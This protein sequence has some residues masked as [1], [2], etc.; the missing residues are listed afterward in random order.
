MI[1]NYSVKAMDSVNTDEIL[2][3]LLAVVRKVMSG[4]R[5]HSKLSPNDMISW[6]PI[7]LEGSW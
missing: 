7:D 4:S 2:A 1:Y 6:H 5:A 3:I